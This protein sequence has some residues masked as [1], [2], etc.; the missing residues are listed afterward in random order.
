MLKYNKMRT[1]AAALQAVETLS[2]VL[3][4]TTLAAVAAVAPLE[5]SQAVPVVA[6]S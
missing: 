1:L 3:R 5:M 6:V 2:V 4:V